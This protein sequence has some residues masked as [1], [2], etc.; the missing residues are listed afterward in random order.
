MMPQELKKTEVLT[1]RGIDKSKETEGV[2]E[3]CTAFRSFEISEHTTIS[4]RKC[5][6]RTSSL[7]DR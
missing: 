6:N 3:S 2:L 5:I 7:P 1:V 4:N